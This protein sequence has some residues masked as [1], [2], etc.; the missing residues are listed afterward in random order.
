M[1]K[2]FVEYQVIPSFVT[3]YKQWLKENVHTFEGVEVLES[4]GQSGLFVEI[5][6]SKGG[7]DTVKAMRQKPSIALE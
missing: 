4:T 3:Q 7:I 5:W 2:I 1:C 6:S